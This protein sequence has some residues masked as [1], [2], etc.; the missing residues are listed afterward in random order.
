MVYI[1]IF[2]SILLNSV[3]TW[4]QAAPAAGGSGSC[5]AQCNNAKPA[6]I[7][8]N[9]A[10]KCM[11]V[12]G[13]NCFLINIGTGGP[14]M[15]TSG[16]GKLGDANGAKYQTKPGASTSYDNDAL[17]MGIGPNDSAGKWIH[18]TRNC[19]PGGSAAT[20]GCIA[21]PCD[22][23]PEVKKQ[24]GKDLTVCGSGATGGTGSGSGGGDRPAG[25]KASAQ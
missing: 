9:L 22:K 19:S 14:N 11:C 13:K 5:S 8:V 7:T 4:A 15:T 21:V 17:A 2:A 10:T 23:W 25:G 12:D 18:K 24:K 20:L 6:G 16:N 1:A 3:Q